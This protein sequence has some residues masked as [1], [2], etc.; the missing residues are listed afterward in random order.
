M[1]RVRR[2]AGEILSSS[3]RVFPDGYNPVARN[4]KIANSVSAMVHV[5]PH[6]SDYIALEPA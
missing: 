3:H 1:V 6:R 5:A 4:N 2:W